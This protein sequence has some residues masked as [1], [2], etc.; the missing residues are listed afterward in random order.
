MTH[1]LDRLQM[2]TIHIRMENLLTL[3]DTIL[4]IKHPKQ[5]LHLV[6]WLD[7]SSTMLHSIKIILNSAQKLYQAIQP[8][9]LLHPFLYHVY[10]QLYIS[11]FFTNS[12]ISELLRQQVKD[13]NSPFKRRIPTNNK[14]GFNLTLYKLGGI[15]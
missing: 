13:E 9:F 12:R 4:I 2:V 15:V 11:I 1:A 3:I 7:G 10:L 14:I 8:F 5:H 6:L